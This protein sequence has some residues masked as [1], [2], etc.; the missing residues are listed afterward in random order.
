MQIPE[1]KRQVEVAASADVCGLESF[2][3]FD[4]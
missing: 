3:K 2:G 4:E 1:G